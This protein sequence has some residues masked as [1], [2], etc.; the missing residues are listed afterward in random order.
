MNFTALHQQSAPLLLANV[1][2]VASARAAQQAGYLAIGTSSAA[3]AA[4]LGYE[5][6]EQMSFA[7]LLLVVKRIRAV[8]PLP[9]SV[10]MEAGYGDTAQE[11]AANLQQLAKLGVV[12]VNLEDSRVV[13]G[14]RQLQDARQFAGQLRE[15]RARVTDPLFFNIRTD[16]FLLNVEN[17]L[18]ETL[19]RGQL[20]REH[21]ADGLFVPCV[22]NNPDIA[23]IARQITLP[24]NVMCMPTLADFAQLAALGVRRISMG[25]FIHAALQSRLNDLLLAVQTQ[26]SFG[27]VFR[28]ESD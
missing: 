8:C 24:L 21:G 4:M 28:A 17:A 9:L 16:T 18:A 19:L 26:Q 22:V 2:D 3:I 23:A 7:E 27:G 1:W 15:I 5:D 6:G 11:I 12:G 20:Y 14:K 25:N 10:D 13:N